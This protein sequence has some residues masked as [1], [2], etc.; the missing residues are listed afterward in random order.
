MNATPISAYQETMGMLYFARMLDKIRKFAR[1]ELRDDFREN[2][3]S[4]FDGRCC[5]YLRVKY[6]DLKRRVLEGGSDE[7]ILRWCF[8]QGRSL[9]EGDILIWNEFLRKRGWKDAASELLAKRKQESGLADRA[10][11]ETMLEYFEW[12]EG[13][14]P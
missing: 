5:G 1:G 14:K 6:E 9:D 4:G 13:R 10:E 11:I 7:E 12:D 2:L 3:G 8:T